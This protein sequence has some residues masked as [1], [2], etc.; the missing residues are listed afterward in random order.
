VS[1]ASR[2]G[3]IRIVLVDDHHLVREG[4]RLMLAADDSLQIV[5]EASTREEALAIVDRKRPDVLL[6]DISL[7][8]TDAIPMIP[9]M[10]M[11]QPG[12]RILVLTMHGDAETVRQALLAGAAGYLIKGAYASELIASVHAVAR[13]ERYLHTSVTATIVNDSIR[14]MQSGS[15]L[16][17]REREILSLFAA[18]Q[19]PA[20]IA[21]SLGISTNTVRRHLANLGT[22]LELHGRAALTRYATDHGV[23][24]ST[25]G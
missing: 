9:G 18:G 22:K 7:G 4:V 13:G 8:A 20:A 15:E 6:L 11:R 24:R 5:G 10:L 1:L 25:A 19:A 12:L 23:V 3:H 2:N 17:A 21:Q 16:T 14:W